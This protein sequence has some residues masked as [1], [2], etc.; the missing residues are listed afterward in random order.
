MD[1]GSELHRHHGSGTESATAVD[2]ICGMAVDPKTARHQAI[3]QG[4]PYFFCCAG[5]KAK[6]E[7]DPGRYLKKVRRA[8]AALARHRRW[9]TAA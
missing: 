7:A 3:H 2:P 5:C 6:F 8:R 9:K 4:Q 1:S